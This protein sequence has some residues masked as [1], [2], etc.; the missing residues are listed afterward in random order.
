MDDIRRLMPRAFIG[1][2]VIVGFPGE[3]AEDF[4]DTCHFLAQLSPAFLHV[5]PYSA[6]PDTLAAGFDDQV[7]E[8]EK[9]RRAAELA[10]L[11]HALHLKFY[12]QNTGIDEQVLFEEANKGGKMF[13]YTR[14]YIKVE[15]PYNPAFSG[16]IIDVHT[17][18]VAGSGNMEVSMNNVKGRI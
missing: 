15:T 12:E 5:F 8:Q 11:S 7:A 4:E 2:D 1:V 16:Q 13:G 18:G 17:I 3:T 6:R 9:T 14:N 10:K